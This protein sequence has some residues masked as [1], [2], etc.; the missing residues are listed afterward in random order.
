MTTALRKLSTV[1][2]AVAVLT[3]LFANRPLAAENDAEDVRKIVTGFAT[4][5]N[6]HD[7][8][9]FGKLFAPDADFVNVAGVLWTGRQ[10]IQAQHAYSHGVIPANSPGFSEE[11]RHY[12]GIFKNSTLNFDRID[13]R[14]LRNEVAI[15]H[16]NWELLGDDRTQNPRRGVFIF[17]LTRQNVGW[18]IAA[19]QNTE[20]KRAVK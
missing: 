7:L 9:A 16:V 8:D 6:H 13:V 3:S 1:L 14:S 11:D 5:W 19:A 18:L 20:I 12:Y 10:S 17:V 15:A 2:S 4:T